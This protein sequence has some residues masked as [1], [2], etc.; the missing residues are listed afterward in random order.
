MNRRFS[1]ALLIGG[2]LAAMALPAGALSVSEARTLLEQHYVDDLPPAVYDADSLEQLLGAL[3]DPYT[4]YYTAEEYDNFL[5]DVNGEQMVGIGISMRTT[6]FDGFEILSVLPDSP[7]QDAGLTPGEKIIAVDGRILSASD[8]PTV[9]IAGEEGTPVTL[10]LRTPDGA[11]R[12]VTMIRRRVQLPI[13]SYELEGSA[14]LMLCDSFGDSAPASVKAA[15][16]ELSGQASAWIM[17][18]R[19]NPGGTSTAAAEMAGYFVG[20]RPMVYF[21]DGSGTYYR[22]ATVNRFPDLTS[23]PLIILTSGNSASA[24]ELFSAAIRDHSGGISIGERTYGKGVAQKVYDKTTHPDL[25]EEDALKITTYRFFSPNGATNHLMGII[26]TLLM[27][28][29]YARSAA[30]MLSAPAP[31]RSLN[32][33]KLKLAGHT[34]YIDRERAAANPEVLT[35]LLEALPSSATLFHGTG[36]DYWRRS[37][38]A[39]MAAKFGLTSYSPRTFSDVAGHTYEREINLLR[40]YE[41]LSGTEDGR[42]LPDTPLTR[43]ELSAILTTALGLPEGDVSF[44]D[45]AP[46]AWYAG[47]V[48]AVAAR[49]FLQGTGNGTFSPGAAVTNMELY[50]A[51]SALAAWASMDGYDWSQKDVSAVQWVQFYEYPEWAQ[52]HVR[53]LDK[54][55]LIV[56]AEHPYDCVTRGYAAG[57]L[58]D[59]FENLHIFWNK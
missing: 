2:L 49:G 20:T 16:T 42:F 38:A 30:L 57:L 27:P 43:A 44:S 31:Q 5:A 18:L 50:A 25:F 19:D 10:T 33:W 9:L 36:T 1:A 46:D 29:E 35:T 34:F 17:D 37:D 23:T 51:Y 32:N 39:E 14:G 26:P 59:L 54:L 53:N 12:D 13:F 6:F 11:E 28:Q 40:T 41:L 24:A 56:D 3:G 48:S 4:V 7:A 52:S 58:C 55:G 8:T 22:T 21:R 45:V 15:L 47:A